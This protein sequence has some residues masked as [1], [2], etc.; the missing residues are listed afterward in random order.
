[1]YCCQREEMAIG[2]HLF[3]TCLMWSFWCFAVIIY[4]PLDL[5]VASFLILDTIC[6]LIY[7]NSFLPSPSSPSAQLYMYYICAIQNIWV[8]FWESHWTSSLKH[9]FFSFL[10]FSSL[11]L[12]SL[13]LD[14]FKIPNLLY[15][16]FFQVS[17]SFLPKRVI[18]YIQCTFLVKTIFFKQ[19]HAFLC[20]NV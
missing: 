9:C 20:L 1:M 2:N 18:N 10:F 11:V 8:P 4:C 14:I 15:S 3:I 12:Y 7:S 5:W 17:S 16:V 19:A 6:S 13:I